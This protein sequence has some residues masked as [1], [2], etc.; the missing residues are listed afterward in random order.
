MSYFFLACVVV[1]AAST[2]VLLKTIPRWVFV[3]DIL[4]TA[5]WMWQA[6]T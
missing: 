6:C 5:F 2:L 4:L 1:N 3:V